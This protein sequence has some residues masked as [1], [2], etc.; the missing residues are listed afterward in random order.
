LDDRETVSHQSINSRKNCTLGKW[1]YSYALEN[2]K[3]IPEI[4]ELEKVHSDF[5]L[6]VNNVIRLKKENH[7]Q[8]AEQEYEKLTDLSKDIVALLGELG[9]KIT[10]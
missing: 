1:L 9:V 10:E 8:E 6:V 2:Y 4:A 3:N 5:H 7:K